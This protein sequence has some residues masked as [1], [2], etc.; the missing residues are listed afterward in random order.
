MFAFFSFNCNAQN[1]ILCTITG[2]VYSKTYD[3]KN[4]EE[5]CIGATLIVKNTIKGT[6]TDDQGKFILKDIPLGSIVRIIYLGFFPKEILVNE[7]NF[8]ALIRLNSI[9]HIDGIVEIDEMK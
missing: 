6:V 9:E 7:E 4:K 3:N 2:I 1:P 5:V 8:Y